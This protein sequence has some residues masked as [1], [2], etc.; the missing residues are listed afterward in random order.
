MVNNISVDAFIDKIT[1]KD[2]LSCNQ[3]KEALAI[4]L[5]AQLIKC[6][7]DSQTTYVV[8]SKGDGMASNSLPL[9]HLRR[10]QE[11]ADTRI[12]LHGAQRGPT[13]I[14]IQSPDTGVLILTL[15]I[16]RRLCPDTRVI[17]GTGGKRRSIP[18]GP[19][20]EAVGEDLV[21]ALPG[22]HAFSGCDQTST[23]CGKSK[24]SCWNTLKKAEQ[25]I[26]DA[27]CSLGSTSRRH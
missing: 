9:Q 2:L 11:E 15:C 12:L 18:L 23:I 10:E 7:K 1:M 5:A 6:M 14:I 25:P 16:Y 19:L 3:N 21:K 8:T 20:Y 13:S 22:F 24:V 27:I 4:L 17:A 26:L